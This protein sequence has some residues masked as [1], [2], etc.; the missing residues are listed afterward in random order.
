GERSYAEQPGFA[1]D[2][3]NIVA[4][5]NLGSKEIIA[6]FEYEGNTTKTLFTSC[7]AQILSPNLKPKQV[8]I[9]DNA[10]VHKDEELYVLVVQYDCQLIYLPPYSPDFNPIEKFW[11]NFKRILRK[12][13]KRFDD[14]FDAITFAMQLT[15][16]A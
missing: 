11:A 8:V 5:Y 14:F 4:G 2:R 7:F 12:V 10:S 6:P 16:S 13:I 9:L 15:Q 3:R 1:S